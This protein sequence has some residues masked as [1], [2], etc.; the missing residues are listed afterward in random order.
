MPSF[1]SLATDRIDFSR[2]RNKLRALRSVG[3]PYSAGDV[4]SSVDDASAQRVRIASNL[5][6]EG[7]G[8]IDDRSEVVA[9]IAYLQRL[10]TKADPARARTSNP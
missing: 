9:L 10:G 8:T 7:I 6:D 4:E 5:R 1:P 2:T 3:V